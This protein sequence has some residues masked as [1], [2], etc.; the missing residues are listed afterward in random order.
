[1]ITDGCVEYGDIVL[2]KSSIEL[3]VLSEGIFARFD[4]LGG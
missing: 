4:R 1:M 2:E 3:E